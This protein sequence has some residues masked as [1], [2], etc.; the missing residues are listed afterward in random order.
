MMFSFQVAAIVLL[1]DIFEMWLEKFPEVPPTNQQRVEFWKQSSP[2][3]AAAIT[4]LVDECNVQVFYIRGNHDREITDED[5]NSIFNNKV[6]FVPCTLILKMK[7]SD[8]NEHRIRFA[9]GHEYDIFNSYMLC[10]TNNLL[11]DK[12]I[13]YYIARAVATS[14]RADSDG[15]LEDILI[16]LASTLLTMVP[17]ALEDDLVDSLLDRDQH[18]KLIERLFEGAFKVKDID[19]MLH[20]KCRI[21]EDK[22]I[23]LKTMLEYPLLRLCGSMV[24]NYVEKYELSA[25]FVREHN[26]LH[27]M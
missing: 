20:A 2:M 14:G 19:F 4:K 10:Q 5:V 25:L 12:P 17:A 21:A 6:S 27:L 15:E 26:S 18:R 22:W 9:H 23:R 7:T 3:L 8:T 16:G 13:G 11:P 1:G 24:R